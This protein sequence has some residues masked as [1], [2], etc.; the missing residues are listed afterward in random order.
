MA[1]R[2][3]LGHKLQEATTVITNKKDKSQNET[4]GP[5]YILCSALCP[6]QSFHIFNNQSQHTHS[7]VIVAPGVSQTTL[8]AGAFPGHVSHWLFPR[9]NTPKSPMQGLSCPFGPGSR[10]FSN[11]VFTFLLLVSGFLR[12]IC[13]LQQRQGVIRKLRAPKGMLS[14]PFKL[15]RKSV[16]A[17]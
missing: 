14:L 15:P 8:T 1:H 11:Q 6:V 3:R 2:K 13:I 12:Q 7:Q 9:P 10:T 17:S 4:N 5:E 16:L